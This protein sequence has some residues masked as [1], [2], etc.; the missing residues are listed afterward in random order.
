METEEPGV[1]QS[2]LLRMACNESRM[3]IISV[4]CFLVSAS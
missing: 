2:I 4:V 3:Q 1:S